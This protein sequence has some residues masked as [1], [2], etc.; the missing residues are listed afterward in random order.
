MF[1]RIEEVIMQFETTS[2]GMVGGFGFGFGVGLADCFSNQN[3]ITTV[4]TK[5]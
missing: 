2:V 5:Y 1:K 3:F 4:K